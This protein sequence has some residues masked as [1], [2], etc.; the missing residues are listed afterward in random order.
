MRKLIL[1]IVAVAGTWLTA[2]V[3]LWAFQRE[4]IYSPDPIA[5]VPPSH[6]AMLA[7]VDEVRLATADG[8]QLTAWYAPAPAGRPTVVLFPGKSSS[9]RGQRYRIARFRDAGMGALLVAYRGYSGNAGMPDEPGLYADAR[10]ALDWLNR[11]NVAD[12]SIVL[13]GASL[14]SGVATRMAAE[15][16]VGAVVLEAPYTSIVDIASRRFPV[17]PVRLLVRDR[18]DSLSRITELNEPLLV[19][20]GDQ[21]QVI[22]QAF[23]RRLYDAAVS[24]KAG[25]WPHGVGHDDL[26]DR[27]GFDAARTFIESTVRASS[28]G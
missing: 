9:L 10:A 6:Y 16:A 8:V 20:H 2:V 24:P 27:G 28:R 4:L 21:D 13:Y 22:P 25:Y 17:V 23:G 14:G 3:L 26:F 7:G 19:M 18:F 1:S 5:H 15:R 12:T 11:H